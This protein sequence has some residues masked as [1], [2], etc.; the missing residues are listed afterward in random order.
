MTD[1]AN[2]LL[3]TTSLLSKNISA[4]EV[5]AITDENITT[6]NTS[7]D[8]PLPVW[9]GFIGCLVAAIFFGSSLV[10]VKQFSAGDG[11]FFQFM[12]CVSVYIVGLI[13]DLIMDNHRFYPLVVIGGI[14]KFVFL[15][16]FLYLNIYEYS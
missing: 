15:N 14:R 8:G 13:V 7:I 1:L 5:I 10:P 6:V 9:A 12:F 16:L 3:S 11:F 4:N 2:I